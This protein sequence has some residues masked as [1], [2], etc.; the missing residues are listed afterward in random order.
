[1]PRLLG[2]SARASGTAECSRLVERMLVA[3][4]RFMEPFLRSAEPAASVQQL[5]K[6][7]MRV[8]LVLLHD[9]PEFLCEHHAALC[10][11]LPSNAVQL[12]NLILSAFPRTQRLPDPFT[13]NLKVDLLPEIAQQP[14]L[15]YDVAG[16]LTAAGL[17]ADIDSYLVNRQ[18][19]VRELVARSASHL[20]PAVLYVGMQGIAQL[21]AGAKTSGVTLASTS[22][23]EL[24]RG[25]VY[26]SA[27]AEARFGALNAIVNQLRYPNAQTH[28]FSCVTLALFADAPNDGVREQVARVLVERLIVHK[29][30]PWGLLVTFIELV[31]NPRYDFFSHAFVRASPEIEHLF[32]SVTRAC[33]PSNA[34]EES[35]NA[36]AAA[37]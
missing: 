30:H 14:K 37:Q 7:V 26:E 29:P 20:T 15:V 6:G 27:T 1:M 34:A 17:K 24:L 22:A 9:F 10:E 35:P 28:Y 31:K 33:L 13:P 32:D 18:A 5:H 16:L 11:A 36:W 8:F 4:L 21:Q 2:A 19:S 23:M 25:L 3:C 12:R